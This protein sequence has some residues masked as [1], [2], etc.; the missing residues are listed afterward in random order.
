MLHLLFV[1][2]QIYTLHNLVLKSKKVPSKI[3]PEIIITLANI[4]QNL[5]KGCDELIQLYRLA[6]FIIY[7]K[8][9]LKT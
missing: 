4:D 3:K 2:N 8:S 6:Y 1:I 5:I 7:T 9:N